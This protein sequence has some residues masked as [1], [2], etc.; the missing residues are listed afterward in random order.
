MHAYME[1]RGLFQVID[2]VL[3]LELVPPP[4]APFA[5]FGSVLGSAA[6]SAKA[7]PAFGSTVAK[8]AADAGAEP[9]AGE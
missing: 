4:A 3:R 8:L 9:P 2:T 1:M 5:S 7:P 6:K